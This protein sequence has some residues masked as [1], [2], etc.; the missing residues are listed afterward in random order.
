LIALGAR[1]ELRRGGQV[2]ELPLEEFFIAYGKQDRAADELLSRIHIPK[3]QPGAIVSA[4]KLSKRFDQDI[5]AVAAGFLVELDKGQV[6]RA[7]LAFGG[8]AGTPSR[9][10]H[11]EDALTGASWS[12][13]SVGRAADALDRD[14]TP[15]DDLRASAEYR[16]SGAGAMLRRF[17]EASAGPTHRLADLRSLAL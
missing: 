5:S 16:L 3:I 14:F 12:A 11:A 2:R 15:L 1:I 4:E 17:Y 13:E 6:T 7:R 10:R 9:A 8:M